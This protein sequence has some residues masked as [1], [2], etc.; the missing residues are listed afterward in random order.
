MKLHRPSK[1]NAEVL[2]SR[3]LY[4]A[5][6]V[7]APQEAPVDTAVHEA[8]ASPDTNA[9]STPTPSSDGSEGSTQETNSVPTIAAPAEQA[10]PTKAAADGGDEVPPPPANAGGDPLASLVVN[11]VLADP[12]NAVFG[13]GSTSFDTNGDNSISFAD[14]EFIELLN[15]SGSVVNVSGLQFWDSQLGNWFTVPNG[16]SIAANGTLLIVKDAVGN[17][18]G[19]LPTLPAGSMAFDAGITASNQIFSDT[20]DAIRIYDPGTNCYIE[21]TYDGGTFSNGTFP[22]GAT[23]HGTVIDLGSST[24]DGAS[25]TLS[26]DGNTTSPGVSHAS[27]GDGSVR[28]SPGTLASAPVVN[29]PNFAEPVTVNERV[30]NTFVFVTLPGITVSD[31]DTAGNLTV[32]VTITGGDLSVNDSAVGGVTAGN[33]TGQNTN[34]LTLVGTAAQINAT[35]AAPDGLTVGQANNDPDFNDNVVGGI[36]TLTVTASDGTNTGSDSILFSFAPTNDPPSVSAPPTQSVTEDTDLVF[37]AANGNAIV[38]AD[39]DADELPAPN[40]VVRVSLSV[41]SGLLTLATTNDL[42]FALDGDVGDGTADSSMVFRGTLSAVNTA[43]AGLIYRSNSHF[44]SSGPNAADTLNIVL[45]DLGNA[46]QDPSTIGEPNTGDATSE[47][48]TADVTINVTA[49]NDAPVNTTPGLQ[50]IVQNTSVSFSSGNGNAIQVSDIDVDETVSPNNLLQ[51]TLAADNGATV[52]LTSTTGLDFGFNDAS[53]TGD[54]NGTDGTL[55]FRGTVTDLNNALNSLTL[56]PAGGFTGNV[57]LVVTTSDLGNTGLDT[58]TAPATNF[59][60]EINYPD[61][62]ITASQKAVI[63]QAIQKWEEV[64]IDNGLSLAVDLTIG[65]T[66][67]AVGFDGPGGTLATGGPNSFHSGTNMSSTGTLTFDIADI[68]NQETSGEL[69]VLALHE[70]GHALGLGTKWL[71]A[72]LVN[73]TETQYTGAKALAAYNFIFSTSVGFVPVEDDGSAAGGHWE[74]TEGANP[75]TIEL[76]TGTQDSATDPLSI[77]SIGSLEDLGYQVNY[78]GADTFNGISGAA[79]LNFLGGGEK[80]DI[81]TVTINVGDGTPPV[82]NSFAR[83]NPG[84]ANTSADTLVLRATFSEDVLNVDAGDFEVNGTTTATITNVNAINA[85]TYDITVSGGDLASFNGVVGLNVAAGQDITDSSSTL[86]TTAEPATDGTFTVD[87]SAPTPELT[88]A[89]NTVN[90][91]TF[92]VTIDFGETVTGFVAGDVTVGGGSV[93]GLLTDNGN[94]NFSAT[95]LAAGEGTVTVDVAAN[96]AQDSAGNLGLA[97]TQLSVLVDTT[98]ATADIT[99]VAPDPRNTDADT[100]GITFSEAVSGV[101]ITDFAL[102]RN[103]GGIDITGL[104]V[105]GSGTNYSINLSSVTA[106]EGNYVLTLNAT[107]S[108]IADQAGNALSGNASDAWMTDTTVPT[109]DI[110]DVTPD[111]RNTNAGTVNVTFSE[112]VSGVD[113]TDFALTRNGGGIDISGLSVSGASANYSIDLSSVTA[114][115]GNYVLTLTAAASSIQDAAGNLLAGNA[116]DDW[117]VDTT[118]PTADLS[119]V[120]PDPQNLNAGSVNIVFS[121]AVTG[122]NIDD[123]SLTLDGITPV[124]ISGLAVTGSGTNYALDLSTVTGFQGNYTLLLTA[125]GSGIQDTPGNAI[126]ADAS[127]VIP[128]TFANDPPVLDPIGN[129]TVQE[130]TALSFVANATDPNTPADTLT[131]TLDLASSNKGMSISAVN[132]TFLWTPQ[133]LDVG[134]HNV[135]VTVTDNG[136]GLLSDSKTFEITVELVPLAET[137]EVLI[138]VSGN[139]VIVDVDGGD[140]SD[141]LVLEVIGSELAVRDTADND[142]GTRIATANRIDSGEL[143]FDLSLFTGDII[144]RTLGG[145]DSITVGNL[146]GLSGGIIIEDG[147]GQDRI[148]HNGIVA[149]T[150]TGAF[151]YAAERIFLGKG[152]SLNTDAGAI[153]LAANAAASGTGRFTGLYSRTA[154]ITSTSGNVTLGGRGGDLRSNNDGVYLRDTDITIT[155]GGNLDI[156]GFGGGTTSSSEGIVLWTGTDLSVAGAGTLTLNGTGGVGTGSTNRGVYIHRGSTATVADGALSITG[157][158]GAGK[159][160]NR[161][162]H[163]V[164]STLT[165]TGNSDITVVGTGNGTSSRNI[166]IDLNRAI[167]SAIGVGNISLTGTATSGAAVTGSNNKGVNLSLTQLTANAGDVTLA[168]FGGSGKSSNDG[169]RDT[170]GTISSTGGAL[171]INGTARPDTLTSNNRGV[172]LRTT[173]ISAA[174][175]IAAIGTGGTGTSNNEGVQHNRGSVTSTTGSITITGTAQATTTGSRNTGTQLRTLTLSAATGIT[176]TG[177]AGSGTSSNAGT[178][179]NRVD[180]TTTAGVV[181]ITGTAQA[182]T[183]GS[184][185]TGTQL[186]KL[187]LS[188]ANG[189]TVTGTAGSGASSNAGT[190]LNRVDLTTTSGVVQVTGTAQATTTSS[191]NRGIDA[192]SSIF[193]GD[194][195]DIDG[196]GGGGK[197]NNE[198]VRLNGGSL[199]AATGSIDIDAD[200]VAT[201][202]SSRNTGTYL[203]SLIIQAATNITV[204]ATAGSGTSSNAGVYLNRSELTSTT[205]TVEITGT[206][207]ATTIRSSN[208]GIDARNSTLSGTAIT[209]TGTGGTGTSSNEGLRLTG[210]SITATSGMIEVNGQA[211]IGTTSSN[212]AGAYL[213]TAAI[214]AS[215]G[216]TITGNGGGGKSNNFGVY[217]NAPIVAAGSGDVQILGI[218]NIGTLASNNIGIYLNKSAVSGF[219]ITLNGNSGSGTSNNQGV[220]IIGGSVLADNGTGTTQIMGMSQPL[221]TAKNNSGV[222]IFSKVT[223][224]GNIIN[225]SGT[226]GGGKGNNHG[227][228]MRSG[229][230]APGA[231]TNGIAGIGVRS[232]A[233]FGDFFL[234]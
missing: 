86:L 120:V 17:G 114:T 30:T 137:T 13:T 212:N 158:G 201:T 61:S 194:S 27:L 24:P 157:T 134:T 99:D 74:Q 152:S 179:L 66:A 51:V 64:I 176:L 143:R 29:I 68:A 80:T 149:L 90:A 52:T 92:V 184:R 155:G 227:I 11:E 172:Y 228:Y 150:G 14:D 218:A 146:N 173:A 56:T 136:A 84:G 166:G 21:A 97:A 131:F 28:A 101:D 229:I 42:N 193:S 125:A 169:L 95:I 153:S 81:D 156:T 20:G 183:T 96:G 209:L 35:F 223:L 126:V 78:L 79:Y 178:V 145:D 6:P 192:R 105:T 199:T 159:S 233:E 110:T 217:V 44:N 89:S 102:T 231:L 62:S 107:G 38:V 2:E 63:E 225:I 187:T 124:D 128:V 71:D 50:T 23:L 219:N 37:S 140:T 122:V 115:E 196:T 160:N 118:A 230:V 177:T 164:R 18:A 132:G 234:P 55:V 48:A 3:I 119:D 175:N 221:T 7:E 32:T 85:S 1:L 108:G 141:S 15:T 75:L 161:G 174:G 26:P 127:V 189:I 202:L 197:S 168:G 205:G 60:I 139:L 73:G 232:L 104:N 112:V 182:T 154:T 148:D 123:F 49:V 133:N 94:G 214:T 198:G 117:M 87:N 200:T 171:T 163:V 45:N 54:D 9:A 91:L 39:P 142:I 116:S 103:G 5:A 186:R 226:G 53:G 215:N 36:S 180:L 109:A 195:I 162:V 76:M 69:F 138:D 204:T 188:A 4:S 165:S 113:I 181:Q 167:I 208:R 216:I 25:M 129:K 135:T 210:G 19:S 211:Q 57:D 72:G 207:Q 16:T 106:T 33:I 47:E 190:V 213:K 40:N 220:R 10:V 111:P 67:T 170:R 65:A 222:H 43:L 77:L 191:N 203:S 98:A 70:L 41:S 151:D 34:N 12:V 31:I 147:A 130:G 93:Q 144:V 8:P 88:T 58:T 82:L 100:V 185:N 224:G 22:A 206:A 46:G 83:Q 59:N 121:E